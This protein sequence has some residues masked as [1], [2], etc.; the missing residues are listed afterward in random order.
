VNALVWL[1]YAMPD[2]PLDDVKRVGDAVGRLREDFQSR[3]RVLRFEFIGEMWPTLPSALEDAGLVV[4][5]VQ[6][7]MACGPRD[8]RPFLS[9]VVQVAMLGAVDRDLLAIVLDVQARGFG[10]GPSSPT[11]EA[12][13][14]VARDIVGERRCVA[15]GTIEG[16]PAGAGALTVNGDTAEVVG[17]ATLPEFRRRGV[18]A[19]VCSQLVDEYFKRG[20]EVAWLSA[21]DEDV[22]K[23]YEKIGFRVVGSLLNYIDSRG[24]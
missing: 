1:N 11:S 3:D 2:G 18:A 16:E 5:A 6:P 14:R 7:L 15:L 13:D 21:A 8:F 9:S 10:D 20:G 23:V 24:C 4:Q 19:S 22:Q 17:V 12:V